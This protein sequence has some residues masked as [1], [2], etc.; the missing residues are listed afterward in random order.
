MKRILELR[1]TVRSV[2][3]DG[4]Q[5]PV[6]EAVVSTDV[7]ARDGAIIEPSGWEL[8]NYQSNPVV[9]WSHDDDQMPV[10]RCVEI[11]VEDGKLRAVAEFDED[12]PDAM[13][14]FRKIQRGFVNACSVRWHPLEWETREMD[15]REVVVFTRQELLEFSFVVVPADPLALIV[16][17]D[18]ERFDISEYLDTSNRPEPDCNESGA[19]EALFAQDDAPVVTEPASPQNERLDV[20]AQRIEALV[21]AAAGIDKSVQR[22]IARVRGKYTGAT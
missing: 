18:G 7:L 8:E 3:Q 1:G 11:A 12:D 4:E 6:V 13:R 19:S 22:A 16:R 2:R 10:A 20:L 14:L 5:S 9:L 17:S 15:G 21:R